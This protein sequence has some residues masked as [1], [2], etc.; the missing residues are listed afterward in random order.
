[1]LDVRDGICADDRSDASAAQGETRSVPGF[2]RTGERGTI[3]PL[4]IGQTLSHFRITAKLGEGGMGEVWRAEDTKLGREVAIKVLPEAFTE[5]PERLARFEREAKLLASLNHQN[6][7]GIYEVGVAAAGGD[8]AP[9]LRREGD[10]DGGVRS[11]VGAG[12]RARPG[13]VH[14]LVMELVEG[15]TLAERLEQGATSTEEVLPIAPRLPVLL[16]SPVRRPLERRAFPDDQ[17]PGRLRER[18]PCARLGSG[19]RGSGTL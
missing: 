16:A 17:T 19:A 3:A 14:F 15:P 2:V 8:G 7:A 13:T 12:L 11:D 5:D 18:R 4:L 10:R 1:M 6:I 9:P